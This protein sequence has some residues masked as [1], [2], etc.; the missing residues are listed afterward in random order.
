MHNMLPVPFSAGAISNTFH[1]ASAYLFTERSPPYLAAAL[2]PGQCP[3]RLLPLL[4]ACPFSDAPLLCENSLQYLA[5]AS[6]DRCLFQVSVS[7]SKPS[8]HC[9]TGT[10]FSWCVFR[11]LLFLTC[12]VFWETLSLMYTWWSFPSPVPPPNAALGV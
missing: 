2:I 12:P 10:L 5:G 8:L 4:T 7:S 1:L 3:F 11:L 6:F 9:P